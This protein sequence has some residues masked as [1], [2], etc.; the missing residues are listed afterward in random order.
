MIRTEF[1]AALNQVASERGIAP[2]VILETLKRAIL[3]AYRRDY[4]LTKEV[5]VQ[6]DAETGEIKL[7]Q[8][9]QDVT[10]AGFGRIAAQTAKQVILQGVREAEKETILEEFGKKV[11]TIISGML[12]RKEGA[13]WIVDLGRTVGKLLPDEQVEG[14]HYRQNQRQKFFIKEIREHDGRHDIILSRTANE[15]IYGLFEMEVPEIASGAVEI[16]AVAR[17]PGNRS[18]VAVASTQEGVDPVGACVGQRGVRVQAI[19]NE[20]SGEKMDIILFNPDMAQFVQAALSPAKV[21]RVDLDEKHH[22]AKVV[23]PEDQLSLAI[24]KEGQNVRLAARLTGFR[25]DIVGEEAEEAKELESKKKKGKIKKVSAAGLSKRVVKAL[26]ENGITSLEQLKSLNQEELSKLKGVG[27][28]AVEEI[29]K[30]LS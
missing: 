16:R 5:E 27:P 1:V 19:T 18:K 25:I 10:P 8:E 14:E 13:N 15:L 24:G 26:A 20:L 7:L 28:K 23:V 6:I 2:E 9:G 30:A 17:E 12:Q 3:A 22:Q 11:G 21:I 29:K 4:G